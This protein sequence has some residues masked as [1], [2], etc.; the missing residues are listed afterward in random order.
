MHHS[1]RVPPACGAPRTSQQAGFS[2][3]EITLAIGII[4]FAFVA[5]FGLLPS[6]LAVFRQ[7]IDAANEMWIMQELN[8]MIQVTDWAKDSSTGKSKVESL[9]HS[10]GG[11]IYFYDEEGRLIDTALTLDP[12]GDSDI[13]PKRLYAVKMELDRVERPGGGNSASDRY[14]PNAY[15]VSIVFAPYNNPAARN[16]FTAIKSPDDLKNLPKTT[17]LRTRSFLVSR[18]GSE[19][20]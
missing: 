16:E 12:S 4:A 5:L 7:S 9:S 3:V 15:R 18:M 6:G 20:E 8:T 13:E 1:P 17:A 10:Q 11:M 2:L 14:M 19:N